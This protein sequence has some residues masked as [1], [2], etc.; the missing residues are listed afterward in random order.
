MC[1]CRA[2]PSR[3]S[4]STTPSVV[5]ASALACPPLSAAAAW[6]A[7]SGCPRSCTTY[8]QRGDTIEQ[9]PS[10]NRLI[11]W[12]QILPKPRRS[13]HQGHS[14]VPLRNMPSDG[15]DLAA[16]LAFIA[17][18]E[19]LDSHLV[20]LRSQRPRQV[21]GPRCGNA[22][23]PVP[24]SAARRLA[25]RQRPPKARPP[26]LTSSTCHGRSTF[27][28]PALGPNRTV[29][30]RAWWST[31]MAPARG[32]PGLSGAGWVICEPERQDHR[33]RCYVLGAPHQ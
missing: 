7:T 2:C 15:I 8:L 28:Q 20:A 18:N 1:W 23:L 19:P 11:F 9:C 17:D 5:A 29:G 6:A 30:P 16:V 21:C 24:Q 27:Q 25:R 3:F 33:Q 32:N 26:K 4:A 31:P 10:C 13:R 22:H 12:D 14:P